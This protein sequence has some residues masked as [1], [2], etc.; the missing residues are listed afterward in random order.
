[1][2]QLKTDYK[3]A[4]FDGARKYRISQNPDGTFGIADETVY[5][6]EGDLFG[7]NDINGTN[8]TINALMGTRTLTLTA[9]GWQGEG[10]YTQAVNVPD[11]KENDTPVAKEQIPKSATKENEKAIRKAAAC[12]SYFETGNGTVTFTCIGKKPA[13]DFQVVIKGV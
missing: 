6:Q 11:V 8:G 12:V 4:M 7:A 2:K 9:E 1:M 13:T 10:P 5:T 3:D